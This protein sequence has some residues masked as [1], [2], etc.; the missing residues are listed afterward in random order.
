AASFAESMAYLWDENQT[1]FWLELATPL[2][3]IIILVCCLKNLLCCCKPLSFLSAGEPGN[4]RRK[5]LRTHRNDPECGGI[6]V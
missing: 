1:L 2:A 3:A 6:P 4:S 5:I